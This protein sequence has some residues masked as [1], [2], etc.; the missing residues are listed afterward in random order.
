MTPVYFNAVFV[1]VHSLSA[2]IS[3]H[4]RNYVVAL[5]LQ[6]YRK[7]SVMHNDQNGQCF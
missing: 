5:H 4:L 6:L 3:H 2:P 1:A 7:D